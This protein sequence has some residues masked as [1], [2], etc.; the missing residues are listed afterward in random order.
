MR[1]PEILLNV[2]APELAIAAAQ[3]PAAGVGLLRAEFLAL[4]SGR[5]PGAVL[6]EGGADAYV[7][8]FKAGIRAVAEAFYPRPVTYRSLDLK[9]NE[10]RNLLG[11]DE[12]EPVEANPMLGRRGVFRYL[13][14]PDEFRLE[15]QALVE[16]RSEGLDNVKLMIPFVRT[17]EEL[18]E[19]KGI[20]D[21]SGLLAQPGFE[22]WA[23]AEVPSTALVP[24]LFA[25][26]VAGLSIGSNDLVQL[27][28]GVDRDAAD[29][30]DG[31]DVMDPGVLEAISRIIDGG[32]AR[33]AA[34]SICG[35]QPSHRPELVRE[36]VAMG[37]DAISVPPSAFEA[38]RAVLEEMSAERTA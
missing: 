38:T 25:A 18:A 36:L 10:Y 2:S 31:Y 8:F 37:I 24:E 30:Q 13:R 23:M 20:V 12:F 9:S 29:M 34:V 28:L 5:H 21:E 27:V 19:A 17:V 32:H 16:L 6:A 26:H 33:G 11:G 3:L 35:D 14:R 7:S 4:S 15:L 22:L 1:E